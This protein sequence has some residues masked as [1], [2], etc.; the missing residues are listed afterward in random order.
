M[1]TAGWI[2]SL[3][4]DDSKSYRVFVWLMLV[5]IGLLLAW[6]TGRLEPNLVP[7]S[8][9]YLEFPFHS[10]DAACRSIRTPGYPIWLR[11]VIGLGGLSFV[12][13]CQ[14]VLHATAVFLLVTELRRWSMPWWPLVAIATAVAI[15]CTPMDHISTIS[16]DAV[17]ASLGVITVSLM[18]RWSRLDGPFRFSILVAIVAAITIM[19]R[20]AY[21]F[22]IPWLV[23]AGWLLRASV[24]IR[25]AKHRRDHAAI[26]SKGRR[27][28][29]GTLSDHGA[30]IRSGLVLAGLTLVPILGWMLLRLSVTGDFGMLPFGHQNLAGVLVQ[31]VTDDELQSIRGESSDLAKE[32]VREKTRL[33]QTGHTFAAGEPG[34]TMTIDA[35]WDDM[36]Y[37]V[38]IPAAERLVPSDRIAQHNE[39]ARLNKRIIRMWPMRYALWLAKAV[40]RGAWAIAVDIVMH[41]IFL[42]VILSTMAIVLL[43]CLTG[44]VLGTVEFPQPSMTALAIVT[45]TYLIMKVG[46]VVLTSPPI[47]RFSDAAAIFLPAWFMAMWVCW[48]RT[49]T[50]H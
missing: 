16:T 4:F 50:S 9:S 21:L 15:G 49:P 19:V 35:R 11:L 43:R 28:D 44:P 32:I 39:I 27:K 8:A 2:T 14:V 42:L 26:H 7:D 33:A 37:F 30:M 23:V 48:L 34:A 47:G 1:W 17:A 40:R 36:T 25:T 6:V 38:V 45:L 41:P 18:L 13:A 31:L 3:T 29:G 24:V 12:P 46:F 20:P 22:L 10:L 5:T